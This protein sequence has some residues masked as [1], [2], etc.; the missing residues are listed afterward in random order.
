MGTREELRRAI[1]TCRAEGVRVY[2]DAVINHMTGG[3]NDANPAHR[4]PNAGC[5]AWGIKNSSL[6]C[7]LICSYIIYCVAIYLFRS[8]IFFFFLKMC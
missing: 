2:A 7:M 8:L 3:G 5:A 4:N 1:K 6:V